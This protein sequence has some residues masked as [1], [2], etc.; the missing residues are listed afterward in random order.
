MP[1]VKS[2]RPTAYPYPLD[3]N[4]CPPRREDNISLGPSRGVIVV[5]HK[6]RQAEQQAQQHPSEIGEERTRPDQAVWMIRSVFETLVKA[7]VIVCAVAF[8]E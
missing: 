6:P 5:D 7:W 8:F 4:V 2:G 3:L 1:S